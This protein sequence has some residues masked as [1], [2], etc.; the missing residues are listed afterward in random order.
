MWTMEEEMIKGLILDNRNWSIVPML[1]KIMEITVNV[2][3]WIFIM[4]KIGMIFCQVIN[5]MF[6]FHV[7]VFDILIIH[8]WKGGKDIFISKP[9]KR[10]EF[11]SIC[12]V[13][14]IVLWFIMMKMI[15]DSEERVWIIKNLIDV[16]AFTFLPKIIK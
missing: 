12:M 3:F 9:S 10:I 1:R 14:C 6:I 8:V 5:I 15:I 4:I 2:K 11:I 13:S 16:W 7:I